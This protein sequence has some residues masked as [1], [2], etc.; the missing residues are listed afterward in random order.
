[1]SVRSVVL[2]AS[3]LALG[4]AAGDLRVTPDRENV[5]ASRLEGEWVEHVDLT[6]RLWGTEPRAEPRRLAFRA[7]AG[8]AATVEGEV[9]E[10]LAQQ[11]LYLAGVM[12]QSGKHHPFVLSAHHGQPHLFWF[13][14][15]DGEP[16]GDAESFNLFV[17]PGNDEADDLLFVGGD[18]NN[19][20]FLA[21][22]RAARSRLGR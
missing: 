10:F 13:R 3:A 1:M 18:F 6:A 21:Y 17:V 5:V 16:L 19:Q 4:S 11:P 7:D 20:P 12:T 8:V 9:A 22:E 14:A 2:L 15:R